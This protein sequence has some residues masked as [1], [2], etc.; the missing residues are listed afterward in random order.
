MSYGD[1]PALENCLYFNAASDYKHR[2]TELYDANMLEDDDEDF[3][4]SPIIPLKRPQRNAIALQATIQRLLMPDISIDEDTAEQ[5]SLTWAHYL[6]IEKNQ[7]HIFGTDASNTEAI[8]KKQLLT[9]IDETGHQQVAWW[10][11]YYAFL[12]QA[13]EKDPALFTAVLKK[14]HFRYIW[15]DESTQSLQMDR[16][17]ASQNQAT[18]TQ[19]Q[20]NWEKLKAEKLAALQMLEQ[21]MAQTT[22]T[23]DILTQTHLGPFIDLLLH[24]K[25]HQE[26]K[27][28]PKKAQE[29]TEEFQAEDLEFQ[30]QRLAF[31]YG[32]TACRMEYQAASAM[33]VFKLQQFH[34][35][36]SK[37]SYQQLAEAAIRAAIL[38][39]QPGKPPT[40][41][42]RGKLED[43]RIEK[44]VEGLKAA[45]VMY[46]LKCWSETPSCSPSVTVE[47]PLSDTILA[48]AEQEAFRSMLLD[49]DQNT[50]NSGLE[51]ILRSMQPLA[52]RE[53]VQE[54]KQTT[55]GPKRIE[56]L[57][58][59]LAVAVHKK[60]TEVW[61][62]M[63][64]Q[65]KTPTLRL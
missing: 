51:K 39:A 65:S 57:K 5:Q 24:K 27:H 1:T 52:T 54:L 42:V 22:F 11:L 18:V 4:N 26:K 6:L 45:L 23:A 55:D 12:K 28:I 15:F 13:M 59:V 47:G 33:T 48:A 44:L 35:D 32:D 21:K 46:H 38:T 56:T 60:D 43:P 53:Q 8:L 31:R 40:V 3:G 17:W 9:A 14:S 34:S 10:L 62:C 61:Q 2:I 50:H 36:T 49:Y 29:F 63:P 41:V 7:A 30:A 25:N 58:A 37:L 19:L 16:V 64:T 20:N